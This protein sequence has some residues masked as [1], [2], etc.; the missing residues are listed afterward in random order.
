MNTS[1]KQPQSN[2]RSGQSMDRKV[3]NS[4]PPYKK[5]FSVAAITLALGVFTTQYLN[6][7]NKQTLNISNQQ[8]SVATV[9]AGVFEDF[10]PVRTRVVPL[11]TVYLDAI[12][13]GRVERVL[14]EDGA[15]VGEGQAI[16]QLSNTQLQLD[17]M[18]N[19]AAVTEQLNNMRNIELS[20]EQNRLAHKRNIIEL[21]HQIKTLTKKLKR[22][23]SVKEYADFAAS[24]IENT[25][26][27]LEYNKQKLALTLESQQTDAL[28][29]EQQL[30][31]LKDTGRRLEESLQFAKRNMD[32]LN[33]KA[34]VAGKLSGFDIEVGQSV[35]RGERIG[36]I[37]DPN[38]FKLEA[39]IDEFYLNQISLGQSAKVTHQNNDFQLEI[40]KIYPDVNNGQFKVDF[41]F[42]QQPNGIRRGQTLQAKLTLG[43]D[44]NVMLIPNGAFFQDTGGNWIYALSEDG[45]TASKRAVKLGKRNSR[46]I[47]VI[48]GLKQGEQ[49]IVSPYS[50]FNNIE[51]LQLN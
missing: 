3:V 44:K 40:K 50:S 10:I 43:D 26:D 2:A 14:I 36:Q 8:I 25:E 13:G 4:K 6:A 33:M 12:E 45:S 37:D 28:M 19:E 9:K 32:N 22:E 16:V 38:A 35:S 20:L 24:Q 39:N 29:Q 27:T 21:N 15:L 1:P 5:Y 30:K 46:Y 49:V 47:E 23:K 34:P 42:E 51:Q 48:A 41:R 18:R 31:F 11:K 17:V 7:D